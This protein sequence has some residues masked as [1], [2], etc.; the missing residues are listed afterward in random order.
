MS[1]KGQAFLEEYPIFFTTGSDL[2]VTYTEGTALADDDDEYVK[3]ASG[4]DH[5]AI[6]DV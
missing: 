2:Y 5:G 4:K 3:V 1:I 6:I